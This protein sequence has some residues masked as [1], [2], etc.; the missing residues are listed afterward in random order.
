MREALVRRSATALV[1]IDDCELPAFPLVDAVDGTAEP[2]CATVGALD[3]DRGAGAVALPEPELRSERFRSVFVSVHR[4]GVEEP[5]EL[6][7]HLAPRA[8]PQQST[9]PQTARL[10]LVAFFAQD[11]VHSLP[12]RR[13]PRPADA[14]LADQLGEEA[15]E[16]FCITLPRSSAETCTISSGRSIASRWST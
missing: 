11:L 7:V 4:V 2:Q 10:H 13:H 16:L 5:I 8:F 15:V 9:A 12:M 14:G 6:V 1:G 3:L